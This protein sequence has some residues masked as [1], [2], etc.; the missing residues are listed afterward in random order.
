M[1]DAEAG[2][3]EIGSSPRA[4]GRERRAVRTGLRALLV[5]GLAA[6]LSVVAILPALAQ[7][8]GTDP[9]QD[10][11][12]NSTAC[13]KKESRVGVPQAEVSD[14]DCLRDLTTAGT[15]RTLHTEREDWNGLN[16]SGTKNPSGVGGLQIDGYF[17]DTST[18]NGNNG[19]NHDAQFV[20]RFPNRWNGKLVITG[21]PGVRGQYAND[22]I[23][24]DWVLS[25]GYAFAS[26]DKGNT[27]S[28]FYDDDSA[29]GGSVAE[30]HRRVAQLTRATK[31][32]AKTNYGRAPKRTYITGISNGGYLTRYALENTPELYDGGV[33]WEGTL[34]RAAGPNLL[35][36]LPTAL[37][38]YPEYRAGSEEARQNIVDAG[39]AADSEF[40][41]DYYYAVYWDLTQRIYREEFDP[42]YDGNRG[43]DGAPPGVA[44]CQD[45]AGIPGCDADY[46][47]S[48]RPA[49][50]KEAVRKVQL[51]GRTGKPMITLHGTL[52]TLLPIRTDSDVYSRLISGAG[53]ASAPHR[54]YK[55]EDG[56]HVDS[57]YDQYPDRLRPI[58]PCHRT[59]FGILEDWVE[60]GRRPP[61]N[62]LVTRPAGGDPVNSCGIGGRT[63]R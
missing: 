5:A 51:T 14:A 11:G 56:D 41:W 9:G 17:P 40:L 21:A 59:A 19:W 58:L 16:A 1:V 48:E 63:A 52:D 36:Y 37:A 6:A 7:D 12:S 47:Y 55:V 33:D 13:P 18:T 53:G 8:A 31:A 15:E 27:G 57:L 38:N 23:I 25:K 50:V 4:G 62:R 28:A 10:T 44:E 24:S 30:W 29:P 60:D 43:E 22:F 34:F 35:T 61:D 46:E 54:Y 3:K 42:G 20:I 2:G 45:G 26:T 39:F 49:A 32:A